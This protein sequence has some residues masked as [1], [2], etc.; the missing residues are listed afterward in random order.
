MPSHEPLWLRIRLRSFSAESTAWPS[1]DVTTSPTW[2]PAL[3]AGEPGTTWPTTAPLSG[4]KPYCWRNSGVR[5]TRP[6]PR[7]VVLVKGALP[8]RRAGSRG[9]MRLTG[10]AKPTF[11]AGSPGLPVATAV[12]MPMT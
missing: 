5:V 11:W 2:S 12:F 1:K 10:M 6:A 8:W 3:S 7:K 9:L 4:V